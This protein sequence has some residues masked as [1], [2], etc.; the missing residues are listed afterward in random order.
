MTTIELRTEI[1]RLLREEDNTSILEAIRLL[2]HKVRRAGSEE[3]G[4][5]D[6]EYAELEQRFQE[7]LSGKVKAHTREESMRLIRAGL[8]K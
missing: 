4:M 3:D 7:L 5:T 2:L 1:M 6:E 8:G